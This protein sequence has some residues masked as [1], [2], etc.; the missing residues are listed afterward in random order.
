MKKSLLCAISIALM[1]T[2]PALA[3]SSEKFMSLEKNEFPCQLEEYLDYDGDVYMQM[4][5]TEE[6][7]IEIEQRHFSFN[8]REMVCDTFVHGGM[9][10]VPVRQAAEFLNKEVVFSSEAQMVSIMDGSGE[11][12]Q[13]NMKRE[14]PVLPYKRKK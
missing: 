14:E 4:E 9:L 5:K 11:P 10:Y 3:A 1:M 13:T 8:E 2:K 6:R 12:K 7:F